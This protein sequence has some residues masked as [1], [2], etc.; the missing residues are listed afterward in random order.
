MSTVPGEHALLGSHIVT[1]AVTGPLKFA[2]GV[3]TK[4]RPPVSVNDPDPEVRF[5]EVIVIG[6]PSGS[7]AVMLVVSG[8]SSLVEYVSTDT[9]LLLPSTRKGD[10]LIFPLKEMDLL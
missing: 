8:I 4:L 1:D 2:A 3:K 7:N 5:N 9:G 6:S 10:R